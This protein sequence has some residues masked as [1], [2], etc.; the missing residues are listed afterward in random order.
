MY[1]S[2]PL[3]ISGQVVDG[4]GA[5]LDGA[6]VVAASPFYTSASTTTAGGGHYT[7]TVAPGTYVVS[8]SLA[9]YSS[10]STNAPPLSTADVTAP[11]LPAHC[12]AHRQPLRQV[13]RCNERFPGRPRQRRCRP[14]LAAA[15]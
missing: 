8:A 5:G 10:N 15:R 4:S 7:L 14:R 9:L 13:I 11:T 2:P 12:A 1:Q 3:A 6:T